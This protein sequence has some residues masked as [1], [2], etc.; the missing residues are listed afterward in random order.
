MQ[1]MLIVHIVGA[2]VSSLL[3]LFI[4]ALYDP[5]HR[6]KVINI[7]SFLKLLNN[8]T[9]SNFKINTACLNHSGKITG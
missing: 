3:D 7:L 5:F 4:N 6:A 8:E 2:L 1:T 9:P